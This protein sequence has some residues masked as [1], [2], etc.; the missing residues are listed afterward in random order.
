MPAPPSWRSRRREIVLDE[1][2]FQALK[3]VVM[4]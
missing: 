4:A 3:E 1:D 2:A